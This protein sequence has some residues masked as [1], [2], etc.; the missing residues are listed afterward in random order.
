MFLSLGEFSRNR[1]EDQVWGESCLLEVRL[2]KERRKQDLAKEEVKLRYRLTTQQKALE[3][4]FI[5][6]Q[7]YTLVELK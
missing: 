1:Y 7:Y 6:Q 4:V 5:T 2:L 3:Q